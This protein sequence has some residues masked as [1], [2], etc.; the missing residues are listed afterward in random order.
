[1]SPLV[2]LTV[3]SFD[4]LACDTISLCALEQGGKL[5]RAAIQYNVYSETFH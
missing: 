1:M 2:T 5:S 4:S 3:F